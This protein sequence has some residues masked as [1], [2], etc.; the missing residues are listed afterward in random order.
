MRW[1]DDHDLAPTDGPGRGA[2]TSSA[3]GSRLVYG[4]DASVF[5]DDR[6]ELPPGR[7]VDDYL[8][9]LDGDR[10]WEEVLDRYDPDAVVW[11]E[12]RPLAAL[13]EG[14]DCWEIVH[15]DDD[16]VVAVPGC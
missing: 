15:R 13:L 7:L 8:D 4:T 1:L 3:T 12:D 9:L 16:F 2:R 14:S 5:I 6:F 11:R 10:R